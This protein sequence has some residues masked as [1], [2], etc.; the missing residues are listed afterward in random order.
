MKNSIRTRQE[1]DE[2]E[3]NIKTAFLVTEQQV[4]EKE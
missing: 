4:T 3:K 2:K 1:C